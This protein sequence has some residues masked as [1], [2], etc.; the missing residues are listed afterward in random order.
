MT[1]DQYD[2]LFLLPKDPPKVSA[3]FV[4]AEV[5]RRLRRRVKGRAFDSR[6]GREV[7]ALLDLIE[8]RCR[9]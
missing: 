6:T 1:D 3:D 2:R 8:G 9:Q 4:R 7:A 5:A